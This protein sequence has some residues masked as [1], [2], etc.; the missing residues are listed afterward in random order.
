MPQERCKL[1][2]VVGQC[3]N[4]VASCNAPGH[5]YSVARSCSVMPPPAIAATTAKLYTSD[6]RRTSVQLSSVQLPSNVQP[7]S[8]LTSSSY[9]RPASLLTSSSYIRPASLL[10][11]SP[12]VLVDAIVLHPAYVIVDV[13]ILR[14]AGVIHLSSCALLSCRLDVLL[15]SLLTS[16]SYV[17]LASSTCHH[18]PCCPA[19]LTSYAHVLPP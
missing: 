10:T 16:S 14:P 4:N 12:C 18:V 17:M 7:A 6:F 15:A 8:L 3:R 13:I 2:C 11:S 5:R 19:D 9:V 1:Q